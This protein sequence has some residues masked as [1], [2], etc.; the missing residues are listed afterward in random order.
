MVK[1]RPF[2]VLNPTRRDTPRAADWP[3][4]RNAMVRR[5]E[6]PCP[7]AFPWPTARFSGTVA[8]S[9]FAFG[10]VAL[11]LVLRIEPEPAKTFFDIL[12]A[13]PGRDV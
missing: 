11:P 3:P 6:P 9:N 10:S 2:T 7:R 4:W 12:I 5:R 1:D 13:R 8:K